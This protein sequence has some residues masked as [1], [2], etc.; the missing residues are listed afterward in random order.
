MYGK[1]IKQKYLK[2]NGI[3]YIVDGHNVIYKHN[4]REIEVAELLNK[5]F[6]GDVRILPN[7]NFPKGIKSPD[8]IYSGEKTDLKRIVSKKVSV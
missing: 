5:T 8:Y 7:I 3:E 2:N 4:K 6:G 1:G